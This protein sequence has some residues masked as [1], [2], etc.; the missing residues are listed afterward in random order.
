MCFDFGSTT[1]DTIISEKQNVNGLVVDMA[2]LPCILGMKQGITIKR[3]KDNSDIEFIK[4]LL[5]LPEQAKRQIG[6]NNDA[7]R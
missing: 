5:G 3:D 1:Y 7:Y 6:G 2:T 4:G